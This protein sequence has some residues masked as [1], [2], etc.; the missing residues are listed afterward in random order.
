MEEQATSQAEKSIDRL[1]TA[2]EGYNICLRAFDSEERARSVGDTI[3]FVI[4]EVSRVLDLSRLDGVTVAYDYAEA[5]RDL[6]R[7]FTGNTG[8][9]KASDNEVVGIAITTSVLRDGIAKSHIV[10][11]AAYVEQLTDPKNEFFSAAI[12]TVAH[13]CAHVEVNHRFD[14]A[15]PGMVGRE[16]F[17]TLRAHLRWQTILS[18]WDEF[19]ATLLSA[20]FGDPAT[21]GYETNFLR[22]L[23]ESRQK[24]DAHIVS[25]ARHGN[26]RQALDAVHDVYSNLLKFAAYHLGNMRGCE[27]TLADFPETTEAL[28]KHWFAPYWK[29]LS[30]ACERILANYGK[31]PSPSSF[32]LIG[33]LLEEVMAEG[34]VQLQDNP[35][36]GLHVRFAQVG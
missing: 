36:G 32:E 9:L 7:G 23:S 28:A 33:E 27:L 1:P 30:D 15:F 10:L 25:F 34:G 35:D 14:D 13:E 8:E 17:P 16:R 3:A 6:D 22:A 21:R 20:G 11:H 2:P 26:V 4:R 29:R 31:W 5:L 19:A 24:A 12:H 18:C